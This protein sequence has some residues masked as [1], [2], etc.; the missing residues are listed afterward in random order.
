MKTTAAQRKA[1]KRWREKNPEKLK[2]LR[3]EYRSRPAVKKKH[4]EYADRR[5]RELFRKSLDYKNAKTCSRCPEDNPVCFEF[6]HRDPK[7]KKHEISTMIYQ[8]LSFERI[9]KELDKVDIVCANCHRKIH[10]TKE[11]V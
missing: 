9:K 8:R 11:W 6:H 7:T 4:L 2:Q 3:K 1:S 5:A 10:K